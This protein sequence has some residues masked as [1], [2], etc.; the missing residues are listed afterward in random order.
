[1]AQNRITV[2]SP[3]DLE[4]LANT[5]DLTSQLQKK[6]N[7]I[8]DLRQQPEEKEDYS[9]H[10]ETV[11]NPSET[12]FMQFS[13]WLWK[14]WES[15]QNDNMPVPSKD[16]FQSAVSKLLESDT[17]TEKPQDGL[18]NPILE[19]CNAALCAWFWRIN[20]GNQISEVLKECL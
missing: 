13:N 9:S 3:S 19:P 18:A 16:P 1:M 10:V 8:S 6:D 12:Q 4:L 11:D 15:S 17:V 7:I 2:K 20:P 5:S 14:S